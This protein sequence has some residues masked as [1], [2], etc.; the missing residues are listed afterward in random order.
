MGDQGASKK[1]PPATDAAPSRYTIA[2][3]DDE[4]WVHSTSAPNV[5]L[6][7]DPGLTIT[8]AERK[9]YPRQSIF[10]DGVHDGPPFLDNEARQYSFDHHEGCVRA[11]TVA[12]CEQAVIAVLQGLPLEQGEWR[13][14]LNQPDADAMLAA[15]VLLNH[16]DLLREER[17]LLRHVM[18]LVRLESVIDAHGLDGEV[19]AALP[20]KVAAAWRARLDALVAHEREARIA[21]AWSGD[22][23]E[24]ARAQLERLD[25]ILLPADFRDLARAVGEVE[26]VE[27][28]EDVAA[29]LCRSD[30]GI[31]EV[32][33]LLQ[34]RHGRHMGLIVLDLGGGHFTLRQVGAFLTRDLTHLYPVLNRRDPRVLQSA[35]SDR[36]GGSAEIGGSPRQAGSGLTG[37]EIMA[38]VAKTYR[39]RGFWDWIRGR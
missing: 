10:L 24:F 29:V 9:R 12:T 18:P 20:P 4:S 30:L 2:T 35:G 38:L 6:H 34:Q 17:R 27:L 33:R 11:F 23:L 8:G 25:D 3:R 16:A 28:D 15:W 7:V 5:R 37:Q 13:L 19:L 22:V 26:R 21:G 32:E 1:P 36:W 14:Y 39:R 31:Y